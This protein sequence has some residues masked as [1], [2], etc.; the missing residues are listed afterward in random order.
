MN[1]DFPAHLDRVELWLD[2]LGQMQFIDDEKMLAEYKP[3][4]T[5]STWWKGV[6]FETL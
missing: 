6:Y 1:P 3:G 4:Y 2:R 5:V